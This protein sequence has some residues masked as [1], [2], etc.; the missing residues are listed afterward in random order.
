MPEAAMADR[1]V[2]RFGIIGAGVIGPAHALAIGSLPEAVLVAVADPAQE[3]ANALAERHGARAYTNVE[4]MLEG[5]ELDVVNVCTPSGL[6]GEQARQVMRSG[7]HV[8]VEKPMD[9]TREGL[10]ATVRVQ[11]ETGMTLGAIYQKRFEE[12]TQRVRGLVAQGAFG[13]LVLGAAQIPSWRSQ[14][15]YDSGAW[16]GTWALD[17]GGVVM[18]QAIHAIDLLIWFMGPV[19][20]V[21][22]Y[23]GTLVHDMEAEDVLGAAL[24]FENGARG[25]IAATTGAFPGLATRVDVCGDAG[26]AVLEDE[27]LIA[28][29]TRASCGNVPATGLSGEDR[30]RLQQT[31]REPPRSTLSTHALQIRDMIGAIRERRPP[32]VGGLE[33]RRAVDLI[34]ALY[35]SARTGREVG[36][37]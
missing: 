33:G 8:M 13:R 25:T 28:V 21:F 16:R 1:D 31:T 3:R 11:A 14:A 32:S 22:A 4:E 26:C 7:R 5:E 24:R 34:L 35:E 23:A 37:S 6:H 17:G 29:L 12:D 18:N 10:D 36:L 15:Y 2:I 9:I 19:S 30:L 20:S 27:R